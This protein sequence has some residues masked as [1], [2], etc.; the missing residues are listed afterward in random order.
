VAA[1]AE[2]YAPLTLGNVTREETGNLNSAMAVAAGVGVSPAAPGA[3]PAS[4]T[5]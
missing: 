4:V 3:Q 5:A 2:F 1:A